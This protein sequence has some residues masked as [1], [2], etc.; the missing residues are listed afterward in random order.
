M[1]AEGPGG[2]AKPTVD[3]SDWKC[4]FCVFEEGRSTELDL[5]LGGVSQDSFKFGE[6][7]GLNEEGAFL[8]GNIN[9]RSRGENG[10][11]LDLDAT[12]IGLDSRAI[13][14]EGGKQ[15]K[16]SLFLDYQEI[17]H[18]ISDSVRTP[19]NGSGSDRLSVPPGWVRGATTGTMTALSASLRD[20]DLKTERKRLGLGAAF[21]GGGHWSYE[22]KGRHETKEG[23]ERISGSFLFNGAQ[24][25]EPVDYVTDEIDAS[26]IY[27]RAKLQLR[28]AYYGSLFRNRDESLT[29]DNPF[30]SPFGAD[31]G[32]LAL[33]PDNQ[34]HQLLASLGYQLN[35]KTRLTADLAVGR[36]EQDE[37]FLQ[38]TLN[39]ALVVPALP[40]A[41]LDG[42]VD[43][44]D[45]NIR[46]NSALNDK[47]QLNGTL[48]Y[49]DRDNRTPQATYTWVN[50]D[51]TLSPA[52]TNLPYSFT[53]NT[54]K[55]SADHRIT[56]RA[57]AAVGFDYQKLERTFQE[58]EETE[59]NTIWGK[60]SARAQDN[61]DL[62][63]RLAHGERDGTDYV[64]VPQTFPPQNPLLRKFNMADRERDVVGV[65]TTVTHRENVTIGAGFEFAT[66]DYTKSSIGLLNSDELSANIDSSIILSEKTSLH[67][68]FNHQ[69]IRSRQAG[70]QAFANPDWFSKNDDTINTGGIGV[71]QIVKKDKLEVGADYT[72]SHSQGEVEVATLVPATPFPDL[73]TKLNSL[74]IYVN[75]RLKKNL[76]LNAAYWYET[77]DA[78]DWQ[79][80]GVTP[81]TIPNVL[82]F[83][84][85][86]PSYNVSVVSLSARYKF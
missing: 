40:R 74:K 27:T 67:L 63:F 2:D 79:L 24:L 86:A 42:R 29:W 85:T 62:L 75:Y 23:K 28:F 18:F 80:D 65:Q 16:Y 22:V 83:G 78:D 6:Y 34:F 19:F 66:S 21:V 3:T 25:V 60:I 37:D 46:I 4:K 31:A 5:G 32:Q 81:T 8:V 76:S 11:Y 36:G 30:T 12:R 13:A 50:T 58:V 64:P 55:L 57:K 1:A 38:P 71:R 15:G 9:F 10:A 72:R 84:E 54:L 7:T 39:P 17:P 73:T 69:R 20:A 82:T 56:T 70:S 68:F 59:E 45:A 43:T 47:W 61:L 33:P 48:K 51:S 35:K 52:R 26:A 41:S 14:L 53:E 44:L 49:S 77:Y